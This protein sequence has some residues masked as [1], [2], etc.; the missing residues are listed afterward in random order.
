MDMDGSGLLDAQDLQGVVKQRAQAMQ[1]GSALYP[2]FVQQML[3]PTVWAFRLTGPT[4]I[5]LSSFIWNTYYGYVLLASGITHA[6]LIQWLCGREPQQRG[7]LFGIFLAL[8]GA[9]FSVFAVFLMVVWNPLTDGTPE[10]LEYDKFSRD[11]TYNQKGS[12]SDDGLVARQTNL[13]QEALD[14]FRSTMSDTD[15]ARSWSIHTV[16]LL[17]FLGYPII[18]DLVIVCKALKAYY[19]I[20]HATHNQLVELRHW[21]RIERERDHITRSDDLKAFHRT[22]SPSSCQGPAPVNASQ[23]ASTARAVSSSSSA[24][25]GILCGH[26]FLRIADSRSRLTS[27][28]SGLNLAQAGRRYSCRYYPKSAPHSDV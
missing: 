6:L 13:P 21:L 28:L 14:V 2:R 19:L 25:N 24:Y 26:G 18:L 8:V 3:E 27:W 17:L 9:S 22:R 7:L 1:N 15:Q 23:P 5:E 11:L 16:Y 20:T 10:Y 4:M 12:I